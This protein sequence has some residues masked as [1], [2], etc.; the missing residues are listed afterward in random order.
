MTFP[1]NAQQYQSVSP[2]PNAKAL[3]T[4][5]MLTKAGFSGVLAIVTQGS[6]YQLP[7]YYFNVNES[8]AGSAGQTMGSAARQ[9]AV[10]VAPKVDKNWQYN[11][12]QLQLVDMG[13]RPQVRFTTA[14]DYVVITGPDNQKVQ[15]LAKVLQPLF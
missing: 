13:G 3:V 6:S 15:N 4:P 2:A 8:V 7:N 1:A 12:G 5:D 14:N 11:N 10:L 9:V